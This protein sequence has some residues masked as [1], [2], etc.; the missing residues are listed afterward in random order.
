MIKAPDFQSRQTVHSL[1]PQ[2]SIGGRQLR[3]LHRALQD[4]DLVAQGKNLQ[5]ESRTAPKRTGKC[6]DERGE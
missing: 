3:S 5:L 1:C 4:S 6:G 2:Y